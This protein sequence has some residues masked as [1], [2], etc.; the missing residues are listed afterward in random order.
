MSGTQAVWDSA[1][2]K[3]LLFPGSP[4]LSDENNGVTADV[5]PAVVGTPGLVLMG[6]ACRE[7]ASSAAVATFRIMRGNTVAGG[8]VLIPVELN[9][10]EST[11]DWFGPDGIEA[12][13]G[14]TIDFIAGEFDLTLFYRIVSSN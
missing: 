14:I 12:T 2:N 10:N 7:S 8:R 5:T 11:G 3:F 9:A 4:S 13:D 1:N 6:F